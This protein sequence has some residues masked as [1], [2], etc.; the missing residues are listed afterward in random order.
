MAKLFVWDFHGVLE[1]NN[2]HAVI[3]V[4]NQVLEEFG[5]K[6]RLDIELCKKLYGRKWHVYFKKLHPEADDAQLL[7]M[8]ERGVEISQETDVIYRHIKP[9]DYSHE[10]LDKIKKAGHDNIILSNTHPKA[11]DKYLDSVKIMHFIDHKIGA[12]GHSKINHENSK[13]SLLGEFIKSKKYEKIIVIGDRDTDI[14]VGKSIGAV[15]YFFLNGNNKPCKE[16]DYCIDDLRDVLK[17]V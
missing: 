1:K 17:E 5:A 11:L 7:K 6:D 4:T 10:V 2:E 12:D 16:A 3:E 15:T 9:M 8:V 14:E 13:I